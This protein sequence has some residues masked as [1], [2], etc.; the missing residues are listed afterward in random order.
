[1][2]LGGCGPAALARYAQATMIVQQTTPSPFTKRGISHER[3]RQELAE[4][5]RPGKVAIPYGVDVRLLSYAAFFSPS[6][7]ASG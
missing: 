3:T 1:M 4:G 7:L 6:A 2:H 5:F